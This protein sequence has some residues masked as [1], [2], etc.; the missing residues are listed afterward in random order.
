M[1]DT[2]KKVLEL[3]KEKSVENKKPSRKRS[4]KKKTAAGTIRVDKVY[5]SR[6]IVSGDTDEKVEQIPI[7]PFADNAMVA[8]IE[9]ASQMTI[10]LGNYESVQCRVGCT[11]PCYL[12]ELS[13]CYDTAQ[14]F[15]DI[16]LSKEVKE[17]RE[18]RSKLKKGD[19][20]E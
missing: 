20:D 6:G 11:L 18:Y 2:M 10:N 14:H 3:S 1:N 16:K 8:Q 12:E 13:D 19:S 7:K 15:V 9:V 17:I 5:K 4:A